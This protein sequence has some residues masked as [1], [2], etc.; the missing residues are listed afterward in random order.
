[1]R[2]F[3]KLST[4]L[5]GTVMSAAGLTELHVSKS[6]RDERRDGILKVA[7]AAFLND[8]YAATSMSTIAAKVGGSKATLYSHFASKEDLFVAVIE[9][10]CRD[11]QAMIIEAQIEGPDFRKTFT[12]LVDRLVR[13]VLRDDSVA[14]YRLIT[15]ETARFPEL[16]RTY[17]MSG[18]QKGM[19]TLIEY[20]E[21]AQKA[22]KL[23]P[24]NPKKMAALFLALCQGEL[25]LQKL[26]NVNPNP[27]EE[28]I[29]AT[30]GQTVSVF[31]A[32]Y[33]A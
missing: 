30:I 21:R 4:Q 7:Y 16:G 20:F 12:A 18:R 2:R 1:M 23:K 9:E 29:K 10:K 25:S 11:V 14:I 24:A 26:W 28:E 32:T 33:G 13:V 19:Q 5:Y 15:A 27:T 8:G 6:D 3:Y 22:G 17:Y 31:L